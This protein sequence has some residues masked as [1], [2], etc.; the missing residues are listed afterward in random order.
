MADHGAIGAFLATPFAN[1]FTIP[2][3]TIVTGKTGQKIDAIFGTTGSVLH[4]ALPVTGTLSGTVTENAVPVFNALVCCYFRTTGLLI[5]RTT[6][7]V[8]GQFSFSNLNIIS[9]SY[10]VKAFDPA[11]GVLRNAKVFDYL[12]PL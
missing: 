9:Q 11:G 4:E 1:T 6:T 7:N 2:S 3:R 12:T 10:N 5:G 8:L